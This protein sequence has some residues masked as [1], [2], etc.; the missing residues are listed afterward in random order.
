M[1][2][3]VLILG[4]GFGGLEVATRLSEAAEAT[5]MLIDA[6]ESFYFGFTK[7]DV[8]LGRRTTEQVQLP[9][10]GL[11]IPGVEFRQERITQID[12]Q[13]RRVVTEQGSYE[14]D[15]LI[16]AL[17][18]EYD[19]AATPG[20][21]EGGHEYYTLAGAE[22]LRDALA[23]FTGGNI[24][25]S[26][27]GEPYKCPPAPFEGA[28]LLEDFCVNRG[29][30]DRV[31]ITVTG[32]MAAPVPVDDRVS[33]PIHSHLTARGVEFVPKRTVCCLD[34]DTKV[35]KFAEGGG[36]PYDL[37]VGIPKHRVPAVVAESGLAPDGW[38]SVDKTNLA[39]RFDGVYAIG[40][41]AAAYTAKAGVFAE[42]A[43]GVVAAD[44]VARLRG[45]EPPPPYDGA[46]E[47]FIE[48]GRGEVGKVNAN[49]LSGPK[50]TG[51][52]VG[53]S[54]EL[55]AEKAEFARSR[56]RRWFGGLPA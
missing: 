42:R 8:L 6:S 32:Y 51:V 13:Q 52:L 16:V 17:G 38:V 3:R 14:A 2:S 15:Y 45:T 44:I 53:P 19:H 40:D 23:A 27:L 11:A 9:Y 25:I 39:T 36:V 35:A 31:S 4:A 1:S 50:P 22:R 34:T 10:T 37:F 47:C 5:V 29:I 43:A 18:A 33:G 54:R 41:V 56:S 21:I 28:F 24:V 30:R 48:F 46:G 20:F 7:L 26:V 55:A 12:P 49:F